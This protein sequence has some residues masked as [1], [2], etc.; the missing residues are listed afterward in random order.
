MLGW[1]PSKAFLFHNATAGR[2]ASFLHSLTKG[3]DRRKWKKEDI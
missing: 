2:F 3:L 1:R